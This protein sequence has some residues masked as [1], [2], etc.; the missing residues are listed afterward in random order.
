[1]VWEDECLKSERKRRIR[2]ASIAFD[3]DEKAY[4]AHEKNVRMMIST[5]D[6]PLYA[7]HDELRSWPSPVA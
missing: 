2:T 4:S 1:M 3:Q 5:G 7:A 6:G